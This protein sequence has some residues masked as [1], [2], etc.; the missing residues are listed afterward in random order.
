[1]HIR[2]KSLGSCP[3]L[4]KISFIDV[5]TDF[6]ELRIWPP[7]LKKFLNFVSLTSLFAEDN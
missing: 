1:M 5:D 2:A 6:H 7:V 3:Q 4:A